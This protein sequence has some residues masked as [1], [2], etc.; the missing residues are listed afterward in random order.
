MRIYNILFLILTIQAQ[1]V[2]SQDTT[3]Y[4][5]GKIACI[6][7]YDNGIRNGQHLVFYKNG[8]I[9][10]IGFFKEGKPI[11]EWQW[12]YSNSKLLRRVTFNNGIITGDFR[13][14]WSNGNLKIEGFGI[15]SGIGTSA[16]TTITDIIDTSKKINTIKSKS[17]HKDN[18]QHH[19]EQYNEATSLWMDFFYDYKESFFGPQNAQG[20]W[21]EYFPSGVLQNIRSY[22]NGSPEGAW[23]SYYENGSLYSTS[24]YKNGRTEG[25]SIR[26]FK[27]GKPSHIESYKKGILDGDGK[28]YFENGQLSNHM[29]Y[30]NGRIDSFWI[31][32]YGSGKIMSK[33]FYKD[34]KL[35]GTLIF[36]YENGMPKNISIHSNGYIQEQ[37]NFYE[38]GILRTYD[39]YEL[40]QNW[41]KEKD[42]VIISRKTYSKNG[43]IEFIESFDN[44]GTLLSIQKND[45]NIFYPDK[46]SIINKLK[47]FAYQKSGQII[48]IQE[49]SR[50]L[51]FLGANVIS[52]YNI[53]PEPFVVGIFDKKRAVSI[54][55]GTYGKKDRY[56]VRY[57]NSDLLYHGNN[58]TYFEIIK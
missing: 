27:N 55:I 25:E 33:Y 22:L 39:I 31:Q 34:S 50:I 46:E 12:Y 21:K 1:H 2:F 40:G 14:Y 42:M 51:K 47:K 29:F 6:T 7:K 5:N 44:M 36:Y 32:Y 9:G 58:D 28:S 10:V 8:Q 24:T 35:H 20:L 54:W 18:F 30:K 19:Y 57:G 13:E 41:L 56:G 52:V 26:Y 17:I 11:G 49:A 16:F 38:N 53:N 37:K 3:L 45:T 43:N 4:E 15:I 23:K 48:T